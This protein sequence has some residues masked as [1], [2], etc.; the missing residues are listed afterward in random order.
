MSKVGSSKN[1]KKSG[2]RPSATAPRKA[3]SVSKQATSAGYSAT[4]G[5]KDGPDRA[6]TQ[7]S[8]S[9]VLIGEFLRPYLMVL[10]L[11]LLL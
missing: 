2:E 7:Q 6:W 4:F 5:P 9:F 3:D 1:G 10:V 11:L 8:S